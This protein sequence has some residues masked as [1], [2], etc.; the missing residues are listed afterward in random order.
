M[1]NN[2]VILEGCILQF[3]DEHELNLPQKDLFQL[4]CLNQIT[5]HNDLTFEDLESSNVDGSKDGGIDSVIT[6]VNDNYVYS[7]EDLKEMSFSNN[8][9]ITVIISQFKEE[10]SFKEN[11]IDKLITSFPKLFDLTLQENQLLERFNEVLVD[12]FLIIRYALYYASINASKIS[13]YI[14]YCSLA[15]EV[16]LNK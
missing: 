11:V 15:E 14:N 8:S 3:Q 4:F 12:R 2:R 1:S 10:K 16:N 9:E 13:I 7:L 5:K 6:L